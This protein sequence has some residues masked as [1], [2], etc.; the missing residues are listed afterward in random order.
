MGPGYNTLVEIM[1]RQDDFE[2]TCEESLLDRIF[3]ISLESF[4]LVAQKCGSE[5]VKGLSKL[6]SE[7]FYI[8]LIL[9]NFYL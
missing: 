6:C 1:K 5:A 8:W 4:R 2:F 9:Y 3:K 7:D